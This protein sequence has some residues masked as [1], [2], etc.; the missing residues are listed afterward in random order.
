MV[1][2]GVVIYFGEV[3]F[4]FVI[5]GV[6]LVRWEG[7]FGFGKVSEFGGGLEIGFGYFFRCEDF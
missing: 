1:V 7:V 2:G 4:E 6:V 5:G 3:W